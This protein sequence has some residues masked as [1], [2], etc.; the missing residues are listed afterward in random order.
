MRYH[1]GEFM[2]KNGFVAVVDYGAGNLRNVVRA[3]QRVGVE[4]RL[5]GEPEG[6]ADARAIVLPGVGHAGDA[7][8]RLV[9]RGLAAGLVERIH[10]GVPFLGVC[11]GFQLLFDES[12]EAPGVP[13]L[14]V[15]PGRVRRLE[16]QGKVPH[17]G[18]NQVRWRGRHALRRRVPEGSYFYFV[19]SYVGEPADGAWATGYTDYETEFV[20]AL[21]RD[22]V[23]ATQFHPEKS[24]AVGLQIYRNFVRLAEGEGCRGRGLK[25]EC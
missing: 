1:M 19:H 13:C 24:G 23:M 3:L 18:W 4:A 25:A 20:S 16:V 22:N 10:R 15:V 6:L 12:E 9:E 14:G 7:M 5:V 2:S 11:L 8:G 17:M 21:A